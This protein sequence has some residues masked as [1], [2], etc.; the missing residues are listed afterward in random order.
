M[1]N[2]GI[3]SIE[4]LSFKEGVRRRIPMYLGTSDTEGIYQAL[5]EVINN[6]TD[7]ALMGYGDT[8]TITVNE[9]DNYVSVSDRGRGC[10]FGIRENGENVFVSI[11][12]KPHTG[13]KFS[14][15]SYVTSSGLNGIGIKATCLSSEKFEAQSVRDG[16]AAQVF[17][18]KG[19]LVNYR[20]TDVN[21][22]NGTYIRFKPDKEVF[23][24]MEE[25]FSYSRICDEIKN[26]SYLNKKIHFIVKN[27][28]TNE[29]KD[30]Y[31]ENGIADFI[32]DK[33]KQPLM[34][35]PIIISKSD[36]TD[37]LEIAFMWTNDSYQEYV[38]VNGLFCPESGSPT[39]GAKTTITTSIKRLS[40]KEFSPDLIRR[41]LVYAINCKVKNPSFANQTKSRINNPSLRT[42]ASQAFKEGLEEFSHTNE[43]TVLMEAMS[44]FQKAEDAAEKK[45]Q[46]V[47]NATKEFK[48]LNKQKINYLKKLSDAE[49]L[50]EDSILC[51]VEGN[52]AGNACAEGRDPKY[53]GILRLRGKMRNGLKE[54]EDGE[55]YRNEEIKL[56]MYALGIGINSYD[57]KK[58]RYGKIAICVD[59]DDDG[60]HV[61]LLLLANLYKLCP[62]F[63]EENRI[64]WLRSPLFI[65]Q[66][67]KGN[68]ISW[69]Y[70]NEDFDKVRGK[71]KGSVKRIKGLGGLNAKDLKATMFSSTAQ[72]MDKIISSKEGLKQL[73]DL[74]SSA[75]EPRKE[76]VMKNIDFS[77]Y[78]DM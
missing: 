28:L 7:E 14:D 19:E 61:A 54:N 39:T 34:K 44:K 26:I 66:D 75:V 11:F 20:E 46:E 21:L 45:R 47:L 51:V 52:S 70:T 50:G 12:S 36:G 22:P 69:Y 16:R 37:E 64:Y 29:E 72:K 5:K 2:Y 62:Q 17:F 58:L 56:L 78:G 33:V 76:F 32:K 41:G 6:S 40:G 23:K 35:S 73:C 53:Y 49:E 38:F 18:E 1:D 42:L 15:K 4:S 30:F 77:K 67:K 3:D 43:F 31:S 27:D 68:P 25:G 71:L 57:H 55:Y 74:M 48:E 24:D 13:G 10:P 63:I 60:F 8:I 65:E 9:Q 59:A